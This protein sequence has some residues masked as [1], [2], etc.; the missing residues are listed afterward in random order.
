MFVPERRGG[1]V[2][3]LSAS[4]PSFFARRGEKK[5]RA[6]IRWPLHVGVQNDNTSP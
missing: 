6:K 5:K 3:S 4:P 2:F 1:T